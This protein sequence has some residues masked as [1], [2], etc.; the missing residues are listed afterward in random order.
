VLKIVGRGNERGGLFHAAGS[1]G[2]LRKRG[3]GVERK[4]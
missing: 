1:S 2:L 3:G 4:G